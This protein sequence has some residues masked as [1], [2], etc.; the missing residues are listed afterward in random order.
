MRVNVIQY[1]PFHAYL[2]LE[3]NVREEDLQLTQFPDW[4]KWVINCKTAGP[5]YTLIIDHHI[6]AC[7]GVFLLEWHKAEAWVLLSTF[8]YRYVKTAFREIKG[9]L[10]EIIKAYDL[11]RVQA[12]VRPNFDSGKRLMYHLGFQEEGILRAY[13]PS[14]EDYSMFSRIT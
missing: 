7:G 9:Y 2:I 11:R 8:F 10:K 6:V 14:G 4:E 12:L 5:A 3:K 13:G 1:E